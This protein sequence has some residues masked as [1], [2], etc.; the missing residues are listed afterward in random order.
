M[1]AIPT[2]PAVE[3]ASDVGLYT[4]D[5]ADRGERV[6]G[7]VCAACHGLG[8]FQGMMFE[9]TWMAEPIGAF[10]QHISIAMPQDNPGSLRPEEYAEIVAYILRLN[11][12]P[13]GNRE[14]PTDTAVLATYR[15]TE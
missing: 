11:G 8:E 6:F 13:A 4:A 10:Y 2:L 3:Q 7:D 15:W 12:A 1:A 5:Q 9:I 14:I